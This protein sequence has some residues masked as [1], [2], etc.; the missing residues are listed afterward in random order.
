[1]FSRILV[2]N[3]GEIALRIIRTCQEL[4]IESV[5]V[6]SEAD[7]DAIYLKH[8]TDTICIGPAPAA[9]SYLDMSR[10][11]SAAEI[12]D[13]EAIHPGYGFLAENVHFAEVCQSCNIVFIGPNPAPSKLVGDKVKTIEIAKSIGIP[14]ITGS[15]S[16]LK[17]ENEALR[18]VHQIGYPV[19]LKASYG[20]G[21]RGMRL[22]HN[23]V[24]LVNSFIAAQSEAKSAFK[25][26]AVYMEK[27]VEQPRHIEVQIAADNYGNVI[28][29]GERECSL[30]R[31]HQKLVEEAPAPN[32][33]DALR[34][35]ICA[36]AV[37]LAKKLNYNNAGTVEFL[38]D[39]NNNFYFI[40]MN[41]R[42]Q[43]EHPVTEMV[44]GLDIV[45]EQ[46]RIASGERLNR[47]QSD[48]AFGG[49]SMECR[50]NAEDP[51]DDFRPSAGQIER[52]YQP[53]GIGVRVD[54][55]I[56][57]G[58]QVTPYYDSLLGKLIIHRPS[59]GEAIKA[60]QRALGEFIV[61]G[62][63]TNIPLHSA[64]FRHP[65]FIEGQFDT[66]FIE[67]YFIK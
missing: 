8:A 15:G 23:D 3:R 56:H 9:K 64:I 28:H 33:P 34:H 18:I 53:G 42:I 27:Y 29:L 35:K 11:I 20:G 66:T 43:V 30:Q 47:K 44:T 1:M 51:L 10:I 65:K 52:Y 46:I 32:I 2:A 54:S 49:H 24:S 61:E 7:K 17:D 40:E 59:R 62:I 45:R 67:R 4:G 37:A 60:M 13:V 6:Y 19:I 26:G 36:A 14:V 5:A 58:Y 21:G 16:A 57:Q 38:I 12:T 25:D 50:I 41:G 63:K 39:K 22:A 31:R 55:H 48:V